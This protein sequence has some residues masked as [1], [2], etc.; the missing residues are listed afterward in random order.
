MSMSVGDPGPKFGSE[1][2]SPLDARIEEEE[3]LRE[4]HIEKQ[5][6]A[7]E[8]GDIPQA[9]SPELQNYPDAHYPVKPAPEDE[10]KTEQPLTGTA[11]TAEEHP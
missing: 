4:Q 3:Q 2:E 9:A 1:P 11:A 7:T 5:D 8:A 10:G 6:A